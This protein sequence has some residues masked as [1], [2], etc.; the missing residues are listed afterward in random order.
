MT[1]LVQVDAPSDLA[2][3]YVFDATVDGKTVSC[4]CI[5][6]NFS[7]LSVLLNAHSMSLLLSLS[8]FLLLIS[9]Q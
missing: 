9:S 4:R 7:V 8:D 5:F 2:E 3:G 1:K 6:V